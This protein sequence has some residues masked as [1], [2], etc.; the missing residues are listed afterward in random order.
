MVKVD[1]RVDGVLQSEKNFDCPPGV[2]TV[3]FVH[4]FSEDDSGLSEGGEASGGKETESRSHYLEVKID[5]DDLLPDNNYTLALE[6]RHTIPILVIDGG[7]A[8][9]LW[10]SDGGMLAL[11]LRSAGVY[12]EEGLFTVTH[13][14]LAE[15]EEMDS[16]M[17]GAFRAVVLADVPSISR[18][19]QFAL[20]QFVEKGGGLMIGLGD[21]A[22]PVFYNKLH[23][24]GEGVFP[25]VMKEKVEYRET[26]EPFHPRFPAG[27]A[28]HILDI[29]D[30][31]R[32]RVLQ[33]ARVTRYWQCEPAEDAQ[34]FAYFN[35]DPFLVYRPF[36]EGMVILWSTTMNH[37]WSN[38]PMTQDYLP[39]VQNFLIYL[40][41]VVE[42]PV[43]LNQMDTLV[44]TI[45][46]HLL[47]EMDTTNQL[48]IC[49]LITPDGKEHE[50]EGEVLGGEW[51][52]EWQNTITTGLYTVKAEGTEPAY[53]AVA[54]KP[55]EDLLTEME[56]DIKEVM[57]EKVV[58]RFLNTPGELEVAIQEE[59]GVSEWWRWFVFAAAALLCGELFLGLRFSA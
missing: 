53:Y 51:V 56:D 16:E 42:P 25:V 21:D 23:D 32:A 7:S 46:G 41:S 47:K 5:D 59:T 19:Q 2:H 11:A 37:E 39:L 1:F 28:S 24:D 15:L 45:P 31:T 49:T 26:E 57:G 52:A 48:E 27:A 43:N 33:E 6:V 12:G 20:E 13:Q 35:D 9:E 30:T 50:V 34:T 17:L 29:F 44:Y 18:N 8:E 58:H 3:D 22:D 55:G 10:G 14:S 54:F 4:Q 40:S 36:G 38:F